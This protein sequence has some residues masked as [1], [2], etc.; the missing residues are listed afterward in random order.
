MDI[1]VPVVSEYLWYPSTCSIRVPVVSVVPS[2]ADD[3]GGGGDGGDGGGDGG[4]DFP[5]TLPA[6]PRPKGCFR[7]G[8]DTEYYE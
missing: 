6:W 8:G 7:G 5:T 3:G 4:G 1:R 2:D